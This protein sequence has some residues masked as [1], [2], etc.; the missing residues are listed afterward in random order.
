[1]PASRSLRNLRNLRNLRYSDAPPP[2]LLASEPDRWDN[3]R[4][5]RRSPIANTCHSERTRNLV[6]VPRSVANDEILTPSAQ[7]DTGRG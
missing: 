1:M 7:D 4:L 5:K 3:R 6:I 2:P